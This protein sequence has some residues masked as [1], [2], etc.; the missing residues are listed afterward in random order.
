MQD[1]RGS[2]CLISMIA[3]LVMVVTG[4]CKEAHSGNGIC[5]DIFYK[6]LTIQMGCF[7]FAIFS[8][9]HSFLNSG[10]QVLY[11]NIGQRIMILD[12]DVGCDNLF[13]SSRKFFVKEYSILISK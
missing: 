12:E 5:L 9:R 13:S 2:G 10:L 8:L 11:W 1:G 3:M 6:K 7:L 4:Q